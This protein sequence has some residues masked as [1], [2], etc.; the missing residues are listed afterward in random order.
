M[1]TRE[2]N[3]ELYARISV[4]A[5]YNTRLTSPFEARIDKASIVDGRPA[6]VI[7]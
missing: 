4:A 7:A 6:G 3:I 5:K 1:E 2:D